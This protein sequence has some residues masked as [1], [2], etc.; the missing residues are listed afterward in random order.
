MYISVVPKRPY[1]KS[2]VGLSVH[3]SD[4]VAG[5]LAKDSSMI[6]ADFIHAK[7]ILK[8]WIWVDVLRFCVICVSSSSSNIAEPRFHSI[9]VYIY[10][11]SLIFLDT[12]LKFYSF[13]HGTC[14][15][16]AMQCILTCKNCYHHTMC[17]PH[18]FL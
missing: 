2:K 5:R 4:G 7:Y 1:R 6:H 3:S 8:T 13:I 12:F 18:S 14:L 16:I 9:D 17:L 10:S 15:V 11:V